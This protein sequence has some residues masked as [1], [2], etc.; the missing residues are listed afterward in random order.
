ME[1]IDPDFEEK[2]RQ[3]Q[4]PEYMRDRK[5]YDDIEDLMRKWTQREKYDRDQARIRQGMDESR[6][7]RKGVQNKKVKNKNKAND[8]DKAK[9]D[10]NKDKL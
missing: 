1:D 8:Q 3:K 7:G 6:Q 4:Y 2:E 10:K 9:E 5:H